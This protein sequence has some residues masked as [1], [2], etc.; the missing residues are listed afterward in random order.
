MRDERSRLVDRARRIDAAREALRKHAATHERER[1]GVPAELGE[2]IADF[3]Q[4]HGSA[5][6]RAKRLP[7]SRTASGTR[8]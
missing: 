3:G 4:E 5:R 8:P 6:R 7:S 2:A 1:R